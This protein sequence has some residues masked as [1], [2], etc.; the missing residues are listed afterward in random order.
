MILFNRY[1]HLY[2]ILLSPDTLGRAIRAW[3]HC[4]L[5][6][7]PLVQI[8]CYRR[9]QNTQGQTLLL[10]NTQPT[11]VHSISI[12]A[13]QATT[14]PATTTVA[15]IMLLHHMLMLLMAKVRAAA[16]VRTMMM[17]LIMYKGE[18]VQAQCQ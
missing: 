7:D 4:S 2:L 13:L 9:H 17:M 8:R 3:L 1:A 6:H 12:I 16:I 14:T 10:Q 18:D 11:L 15:V 5:P